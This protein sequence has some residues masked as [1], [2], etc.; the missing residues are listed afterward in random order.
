LHEIDTETQARDPIDFGWLYG[1]KESLS[2]SEID[3]I[4]DTNQLENELR[5]L[6]IRADPDL[7]PAV[8]GMAVDQ[9]D[10]L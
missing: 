6:P 7:D 8:L 2:H 10:K 9:P 3:L 5:R 1:I 4:S